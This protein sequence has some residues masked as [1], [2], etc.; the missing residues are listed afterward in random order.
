M[1]IDDKVVKEGLMGVVI[2]SGVVVVVGIIGGV[3]F[4]NLGRK[5]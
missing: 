5:R 1:L 2:V 4:R 3:L